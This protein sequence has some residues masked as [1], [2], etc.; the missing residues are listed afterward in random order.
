MDYIYFNSPAYVPFYAAHKVWQ[1]LDNA[2]TIDPE[3]LRLK[4]EWINARM[5]V[6]GFA[7]KWGCDCSRCGITIQEDYRLPNFCPNC[8]ADMRGDS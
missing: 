2:P 5:L 1:V 3:S 7:E 4:G 8:G 6:G